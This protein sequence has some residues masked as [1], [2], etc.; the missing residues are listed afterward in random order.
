[1]RRRPKSALNPT[2]SR[3]LE[4]CQLDRRWVRGQDCWLFD[5]EGRWF[6]DGYAQYGAVILG[7]NP[8]CGV[9]ALRAGLDAAEPAMVQPYQAP[10]AVALAE[11]LIAV[12]PG[13]LAHCVFTTSGAQAVEA[14]IKLVRAKTG[15]PVIIAALGGY[16][17]KTIATLSLIGATR[18]SA[19]F[20][21]LAPGFVQVPYGDAE[22]LAACLREHQDQVAGVLLEPIQGE[23]GVHLPPPGYLTDVRELCTAHGA[24]LIVDEIQTGLGRTGRLFACEHD[25]VAPDVMLIAKGISGGLVPLGACLSSP[26]FWDARFGLGH[27]STFANNNLAC[28]V[29]RAVLAEIC[30][31]NLA[32]AAERKGSWLLARLRRLAQRHPG[33]IKEVRGR[34]LLCAIELEPVVASRG[35]L[36]ATLSHHGLYAYA[37]AAA[38][39]RCASL[40][41]APTLGDAPVLRLAPPLTISDA[42]LQ[43]LMQA[44]EGV[45]AAL[46]S[47]GSR[48]I[49]AALQDGTPQ[50]PS[51][52]V[53]LP[54]PQP[55]AQVDYAFIAHLLRPGDLALTNPG[56][57]REATGLKRL[58]SFVAQLPPVL[59]L[60]APPIH[61][62]SGACA[63]GVV[64]MLPRLP[65][66][67]RRFG[68]RQSCQ[69]IR[70]AVELAVSL[71]ARVVGLG[72]HTTPFSRHGRAVVG[73][74]A[75]ITTGNALTAS[76]A[77]ASLQELLERRGHDLARIRVAIVGAGSVGGLCARLLVRAG[78]RQ[79]LL[80]G[81]PASGCGRLERLRRE[82]D[83]PGRCIEL[84]RDLTQLSDVEAV[85]CAS[86]SSGG[87][88]DAAP[89][90]P[91]AIVC[92]LARP[93]DTTALLRQR[94]DLEVFEG[95]L[96]HLPDAATSFGAGNL[97]GLPPGIQLACLSETILLALDAQAGGPPGPDHV[98]RDLSL[99]CADA[100]RALAARHGFVPVSAAP[101]PTTPVS[102]GI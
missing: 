31:S 33:L 78:A 70:E 68:P 53:F 74:G 20:G 98:G 45:F 85:V 35:S 83:G 28:R 18:H 43:L 102:I 84:S 1:M 72:G 50:Q 3:L 4:L 26:A 37:V 51:R 23:S 82:L 96:L 44:L 90:R 52:P 65:A 36:L 77:I 19:G 81:N 5:D 79:L 94:P 29:G 2:L 59:M 67:L 12:S 69:L 99:V 86:T 66:E 47:E 22:A 6:L 41:V 17:G 57:Q 80:L 100:M 49:V 32:Q 62:T 40:L 7:H 10:H 73:L 46:E 14:A 38:L 11:E 92:D 56:L 97:V 71:G 101:D 75:R 58:C 25:Q 61:S 24:A 9:T 63:R 91:A 95:G 30:A 87:L 16:H 42:E 60:D 64:I 55:R 89:L 8:A 48:L 27:S 34:G 21:P 88:L 13:E 76:T 15:R 93:S 54:R 39:A